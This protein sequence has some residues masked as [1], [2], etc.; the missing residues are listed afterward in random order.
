MSDDF[1]DN[2]ILMSSFEYP[3]PLI[4]SNVFNDVNLYNSVCLFIKARLKKINIENRSNQKLIFNV[5]GKRTTY[6]PNCVK[7]T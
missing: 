2:K 4:L 1:R 7:D 3:L 6:N 5:Y